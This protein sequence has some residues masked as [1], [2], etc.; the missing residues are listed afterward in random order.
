MD[1]GWRCW[2]SSGYH[3]AMRRRLFTA[4]SVLSLMACAAVI[5]MWVISHSHYHGVILAA[6]RSP[7]QRL[8]QAESH[9]GVLL[10]AVAVERQQFEPPGWSIYGYPRDSHSA[11]V[12]SA[13]PTPFN[14]MGFY[15]IGHQNSRLGEDYHAIVMPHWFAVAVF[16]V[17]PCLWLMIQSRRNRADARAA[18]GLCMLCGY[19]LTGNTSGVCPECGTPTSARVKA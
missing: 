19:N 17:A 18:V 7:A 4:V 8:I 11:I 15:W 13:T 9:G 6:R 14:R 16:L 2:I 12:E 3:L 10:M 1:Q 5:G